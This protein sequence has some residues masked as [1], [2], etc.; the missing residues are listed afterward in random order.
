MTILG[1]MPQKFFIL[2]RGPKTLPKLLLVAARVPS[3][4]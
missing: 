3:H 1:N 2:L 4:L